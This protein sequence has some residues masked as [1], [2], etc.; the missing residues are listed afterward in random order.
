VEPTRL[1]DRIAHILSRGG[2]A[3]LTE[4]IEFISLWR[5]ARLSLMVGAI[6][7]LAAAG[8]YYVLEWGDATLLRGMAGYVQPPY[9]VGK[10]LFDSGAGAYRWWLILLLPAFGGLM[11]GLLIA[12]LA[13]ETRGSGVDDTITS[14]HRQGGKIRKRVPLVKLVAS[15]FSLGT[16]GSAGRE[17]PM[18]QIGGGFASFLAT[19]LHLSVRERRLLVLAGAAGGISALFR[20]PLGAALWALEVPYRDDFESDGLFPCLVSSVTAYSVFTTIHGT[21]TLFH[22][23]VP[24]G[25]RPEQLPFFGLMAIAGAPLALLWIKM[26]YF[27]EHGFTELRLPDWVKPAIG[28]LLLGGLALAV[29]WVLTSGYGWMQD[30]LRPVDDP[31]RLLPVGYRGFGVLLGIAVAKMVATSLTVGSGGSGGK[32]APT[33]FIGGFV[34]GAFGLLFHQWAPDI[35]DQPGAFVLVGMG[36]FYGAV[37]HTPIATIILVSELFGSYDLLVPLMLCVMIGL[38]LLR[39]FTLYYAQVENRRESPV[40]VAEFTVDVLEQL[41]VKDHFTPGRAAAT[42]AADMNLRDFLAHVSTTADSFFVVHDP[43][44]KKLA[45]IVSL[46]NVRT[47]VAEQEFLD[48]V[49]VGDA[50]WSLASLTPQTDLRRALRMFL[51]SGYDHLPVI[52]PENPDTVLGMLSQQ[53]VFSAYNAEILRRRLAAGADASASSSAIRRAATDASPPTK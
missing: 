46:S 36:T 50:M 7:G 9:G 40:H 33:L 32:F 41:K 39:R 21:G 4:G 45:G 13:P 37:T 47:V 52:D 17:G 6:V 53:Q 49:L 24:Y 30:T 5:W 29:P 10:H 51:E 22:V 28:G 19:R 11:A 23:A 35:V 2:I 1:P 12:R 8:V 31:G 14:F 25:F 27:S 44:T 3:S 42:V 18:A 34:G 20:A 48:I 15:L 16:G 43:H 38:L 26:W